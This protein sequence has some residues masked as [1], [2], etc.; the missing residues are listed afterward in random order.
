MLPVRVGLTGGIGSGKSTVARLWVEQ[1]AALID[2]DA[3]SREL[4]AAGGLAVPAI[5]ARFGP[6]VLTAEGELDRSVLRE[7]VFADASQRRALEGILHPLIGEEVEARASDACGQGAAL[8]LFDVPLLAESARWRDRVDR[9]VVVDCP[10]DVQVARVVARSGWTADTVRSVIAQQA[11][12]PQ[13]R[14]V[15]DAVLFN[16]AETPLETL[17]IA[18][19]TLH[20]A[21]VGARA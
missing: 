14:A 3:I 9:V 21:W 19:S 5:A 7:R 13:R 16:G 18:V 17:R 10:A 20:S 4:T 6:A 2:T 1:G 12:R 8:L 11:T 15:A